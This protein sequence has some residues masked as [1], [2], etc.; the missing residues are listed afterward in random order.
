MGSSD[1][2]LNAVPYETHN[3]P[4]QASLPA[5]AGI[6]L[7]QTMPR[8]PSMNSAAPANNV[9]FGVGF[10]LQAN[11][12]VQG[13]TA[14][15]SGT[16]LATG[17]NQWFGLVDQNLNLLC[18]SNDDGAGA[19]AANTA[20]RLAVA[21]DA[22]GNSITEFKTTYTGLY[23]FLLGINASTVPTL[24]GGGGNFGGAYR[25]LQPYILLRST[26]SMATVPTTFTQ[27]VA[28]NGGFN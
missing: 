8:L 26:Q 28:T 5:G 24:T 14:F 19:W 15:S 9:W 23:F 13:F 1:S 12:Y 10:H 3:L 20:K 17:T 4:T 7:A 11:V 25:V 22:A 6:P 27:A 18:N 16:A 21:K 2:V